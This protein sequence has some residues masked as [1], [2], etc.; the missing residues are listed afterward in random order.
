MPAV[1]HSGLTSASA[2]GPRIRGSLA[3][4]VQFRGELDDRLRVAA[5]QQRVA[6]RSGMT[7]GIS[8]VARDFNKPASDGDRVN[9]RPC[10]GDL[11]QPRHQLLPG[12]VQLKERQTPGGSVFDAEQGVIG[13]AMA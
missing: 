3:I 5:T 11:V 6:R 13:E 8:K 7:T 10:G 2:P 12:V 1:L 9:A 4:S